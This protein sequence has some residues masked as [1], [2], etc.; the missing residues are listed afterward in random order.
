MDRLTDLSAH[1]E[2]GQQLCFHCYLENIMYS[3]GEKIML[4]PTSVWN[5]I[6]WCGG[7]KGRVCGRCLALDKVVTVE[8]L[9]CSCAL[10]R[11]SH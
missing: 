9:W 6:I 5:H 3:V 4:Q 10:R 2:G 11:D 1:P 7:V 8:S